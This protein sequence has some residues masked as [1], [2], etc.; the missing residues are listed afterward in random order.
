MMTERARARMGLIGAAALFS[1][2]GAAIKLTTLSGAQV[3]C[4]RSAVAAA[5][6]LLLAPES[7]RG[8]T[9]RTAVASVAYAA[10]LTLFVLAN[11]LTTSAN[12]I[13]LQSTAPLYLLLLGPWLLRERVRRPDLIVLGVMAAGLVAV[14]LGGARPTR[15]AT[16]PALGNVLALSSGVAWAF[17]VIGIRW[18][19]RPETGAGREA[20]SPTTAVVLGNLLAAAVNL[21]FAVPLGSWTATDLSTVLFLGVVQIGFSYLL[22]TRALKHIGAF[23]ASLL[24]MVEPALN[25]FWA[26][27]VHGESPGPWSLAGGALILGATA[28]KSVLDSRFSAL[29]SL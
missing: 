25:P 4:F 15:T 5:A 27:W 3:A 22:L 18:M 8:W 16:N 19:A 10:C 9:W 28:L 13:F 12:T 17:V 11:K 24:L 2:G 20:P 6:V 26:W 29:K 21:P 23:E 14:F 1:T 7:R